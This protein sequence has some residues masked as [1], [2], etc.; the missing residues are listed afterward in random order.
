MTAADWPPVWS[1]LREIVAAGE[2][3]SYDPDMSES[4][5]R[6]MWLLTP[7]ARTVVAVTE[8]GAV[9]GT[10]NMYANRQGG[11]SHV[12]SG[13][14]MVDPAQ[15]GQGTGRALAEDMVELARAKRFRGIQFNAVVECNERA[16]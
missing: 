10:A 8:D 12:A 14:L 2:T 11:G 3:F 6:S 4:D 15:W 1:F 5:A 13:S 9:A 16:A 7:P